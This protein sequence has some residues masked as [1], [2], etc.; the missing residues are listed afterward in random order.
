MRKKRKT[1][2][3]KP[4][5][6]VRKH[7]PLPFYQLDRE[8]FWM[9]IDAKI[10]NAKSALYF[11]CCLK[12]DL[13]T[14]QGHRIEYDE[15]A[16]LLGFSCSAIYEAADVLEEA[17]LIKRPDSGGFVPFLP[18]I[19]ARIESAE[20]EKREKKER[21]FYQELDRNVVQFLK[22]ANDTPTER[23]I[24]A[25]Y[26]SLVRERGERKRNKWT[27]EQPLNTQQIL[28]KLLLHAP[29]NSTTAGIYQHLIHP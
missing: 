11:Y 20:R 8:T 10:L 29:Q 1:Q 14:G 15:T 4:A 13:D 19:K 28:K 3:N 7:T 17:G 24:W 18:R 27:P 6:N 12:C 2:P 23:E 16:Q 9:L 26:T 21:P 5:R 22:N 25:M